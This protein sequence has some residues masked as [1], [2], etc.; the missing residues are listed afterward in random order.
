MREA[1]HR[2][3]RKGGAGM[4]VVKVMHLSS[5]ATVRIHDDCFRDLSPVQREERRAEVEAA[6]WR[7]DRNAQLR[8]MEA[9]K[10]KVQAR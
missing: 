7:I 8:A 10:D 4:A 1:A 2:L 9:N 6:I 3:Q 5:G